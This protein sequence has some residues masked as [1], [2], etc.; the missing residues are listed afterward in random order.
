M[1]IDKCPNVSK[2]EHIQYDPKIKLNFMNKY[3]G[4]KPLYNSKEG[5]S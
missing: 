4:G 5:F 3:I 1:N 2:K